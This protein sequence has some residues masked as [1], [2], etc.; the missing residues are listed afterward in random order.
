MGVSVGAR[1][2]AGDIAQP[3]GRQAPVGEINSSASHL[4]IEPFLRDT[5]CPPCC[6]HSDAVVLWS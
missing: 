4:R 3:L 5:T 6:G 1:Q 2:H